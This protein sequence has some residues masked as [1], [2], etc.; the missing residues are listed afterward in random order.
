MKIK[1]KQSNILV[2]GILIVLTIFVIS[3]LNQNTFSLASSDGITIQVSHK[4]YP[5]G[6]NVDP[7]VI[8]PQ[9]SSIRQGE[10]RE[11]TAVN[12]V[13]ATCNT[14][15]IVFTW[16]KGSTIKGTQTF[17]AGAISPQTSVEQYTVSTTSSSTI[18]DYSIESQYR[19]DGVLLARETSNVNSFFIR[20]GSGTNKDVTAFSVYGKTEPEPDPI[21]G[22]RLCWV[23][24]VGSCESIY[25][26]ETVTCA[27]YSR[28]DTE[29]QCK[30]ANPPLDTIC[31]EDGGTK[32]CS[33]F[34]KY[35][36]YGLIVGG[37]ILIGYWYYGKKK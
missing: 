1:K 19:C 33:N 18:G 21:P 36:P 16:K 35:L 10:S 30:G 37:I 4:S 5:L 23:H 17:N 12:E 28:Y 31:I 3:N 20:G 32:D 25:Q 26:L 8:T 29:A 15:D 6:T 7:L 27:T 13:D 2:V 24:N 11:F 9:G 34:I 22:Q 14:F